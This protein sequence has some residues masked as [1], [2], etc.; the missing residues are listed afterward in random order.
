MPGESRG[1]NDAGS[2]RLPLANLPSS[3]SSPDHTLAYGAAEE[4]GAQKSPG[5]PAGLQRMP[6][7]PA[8]RSLPFSRVLGRGGPCE[9]VQVSPLPTETKLSSQRPAAAQS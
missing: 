1:G 6:Q 4:S 2:S 5:R 8:R 3:R 7:L 9:Q